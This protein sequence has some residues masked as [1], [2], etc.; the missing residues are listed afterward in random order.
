MLAAVS[1]WSPVIMTGRI[2]AESAVQTALSPPAGPG[3]SCQSS[4]T[5]TRSCSQRSGVF[6]LPGGSPMSPETR[7]ASTRIPRCGQEVVRRLDAAR[8]R[9]SE[10]KDPL[11]HPKI[12]LETGRSESSA[13]L[14]NRRQPSA[15]VG[16]PGSGQSLS[17]PRYRLRQA[18]AWTVVMQL[19]LGIEGD[20]PHP[21]ECALQVGLEHPQLSRRR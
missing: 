12:P 4:P 3:R 11:D 13:P 14:V 5:K 19:A 2:P 18:V 20:L 7:R 8:R 10:W 17:R 16:M 6:A 9:W 21:G 15:P 1:G